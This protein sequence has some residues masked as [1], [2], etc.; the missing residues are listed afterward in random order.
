M[1][2]EAGH[3][4]DVRQVGDSLIAVKKPREAKLQVGEFVERH[5]LDPP[6]RLP[7]TRARVEDARGLQ[8]QPRQIPQGRVVKIDEE[9]PD[10]ENVLV[11][12]TLQVGFINA[13]IDA[14]TFS[15]EVIEVGKRVGEWA[16][17]DPRQTFD[18]PFLSV[19]VNDLH[20]PLLVI[21]GLESESAGGWVQLRQEAKGGAIHAQPPSREAPP[22]SP[23]P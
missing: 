10:A 11:F 16:A 2:R 12:A 20:L 19:A 21:E 23:P 15:R 7:A 5:A 4:H 22:L 17:D 14:R 1:M 9:R 8:R 13:D 6:E 3:A 18:L